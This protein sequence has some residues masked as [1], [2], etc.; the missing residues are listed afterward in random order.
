[1]NCRRRDFIRGG[2]A[3]LA[4]PSVSG[5]CGEERC[6]VPVLDYWC[7]W[8][9]QNAISRI[10]A[11][12]R[13]GVS[14]AGDQGALQARNNMTEELL[15]GSKGWALTMFP[16]S[17]E[18]LYMM[19]DDGWDVPFGTNP[20]KSM[21]PFAAL[22]PFADRF[23]G[24]GAKGEERLANLNAKL[25]DCGWRG[26][27][28]WVACQGFGE[29]DGLYFDAEKSK[30][31]WRRRMEISRKAGIRYWKIDWGCRDG[32]LD[33]RRMIQEV[34]ESV[35]P[36]LIIENKPLTNCA[37]F[38]GLSF[39]KEGGCEGSGR[40][41]GKEDFA[42]ND[43]SNTEIGKLC[44]FSDVVRIYDMLQPID[45]ATT[46]D[47]VAYYGLAIEKAGARTILNVEGSVIVGAVLGHAFGIMRAPGV[48]GDLSGSASDVSH[49]CERIA[50]V[51][52]AVAWRRLAPVVGG[53]KGYQIRFSQKTLTDVWRYQKNEG[54]LASAWG[55]DVFQTAPSVLSRGT[56]LPEVKS[57][58]AEAPF[59]AAMKHPN[60]ALSVG[61]FPRVAGGRWWT[62]HA[63]I[64]LDEHIPQEEPLG[65][66]GEMASLMLKGRLDGRRVYASDLA[67]GGRHDITAS[68][69]QSDGHIVIS[70]KLLAEIGREADPQDRYSAPGTLVRFG[71]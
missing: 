6:G 57:I 31:D 20:A 8:G 36:G 2:V 34:K 14:F 41:F 69:M 9:I 25:K 18:N 26:A 17:R 28:L 55:R 59:V 65:V 11:A 66:F 43:W 63:D 46:F 39:S 22:V 32:N 35:Y 5:F 16:K 27:G 49:L 23:P 62:P 37:P 60:G 29:G 3:A 30:S 68:V 12:E 70:G 44:L 40:V 54:W 4:M 67:G 7:T 38:N 50:E 45:V 19:I 1:M 51:D 15:F 48:E 56:A 13:P 71:S 10:G 24:L 61:A 47:R 21:R 64:A 53:M 33:Y 42:R 58:G 52:R